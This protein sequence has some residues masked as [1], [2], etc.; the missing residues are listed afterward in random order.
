[1]RPSVK[2]ELQIQT[3]QTRVCYILLSPQEIQTVSCHKGCLNHMLRFQ[4][5]LAFEQPGFLQLS[6]QA[7]GIFADK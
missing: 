3:L 1:M 7:M 2:Q 5:L 6:R 4:P